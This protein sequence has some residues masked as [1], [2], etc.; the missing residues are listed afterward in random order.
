MAVER[1]VQQV[2]SI[3]EIWETTGEGRIWVE[4]TGTDGKDRP[5]SVGGRPGQRLR[6]SEYDRL[7]AQE[8][9]LDDNAD[10]FRNG[11]LI[12]VGG[13][14]LSEQALSADAVA[15]IFTHTGRDF[16]DLI[17]P[18]NEYNTR[19]LLAAADSLDATNSQI[20]ALQARVEEKWPIG[21]DTPMYREL[22]GINEVTSALQ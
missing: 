5:V 18:L 11:M 22:K 19:R 15:E 20:Q 17:E 7:R 13:E 8:I 2:E 12:R 14:Q 10:P 21:G 1:V 16:L 4:V 6:I 9:I 3:E